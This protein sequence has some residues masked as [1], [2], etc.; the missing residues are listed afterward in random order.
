MPRIMLISAV[1]V[2]VFCVLP[3]ASLS[4]TL[5]PEQT[6]AAVQGALDTANEA[7]LDELMDVNAIVAQGVD[8]FLT[9]A[10]TPEGQAALSPLLAMTLSSLESSPQGRLMTQG[11]LQKT[12]EEFIRFGV[13]SGAFGGKKGDA[14]QGKDM[15][16]ALFDGASLG[17]KEIQ[18]IGKA[19]PEGEGVY[20]PCIVFDHGSQQTYIVQAALRKNPAGVWRIVGIRNMNDVMDQVSAESKAL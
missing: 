14:P 7:R 15:W 13:R 5:T 11:L 6:V 19:V 9:R 16:S 17:R 8:I 18:R 20:V 2:M 1:C 4:A 3:T 10:R 12:T